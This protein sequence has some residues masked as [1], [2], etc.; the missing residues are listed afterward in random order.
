MP[1]FEG[2]EMVSPH[3]KNRKKPNTQDGRQLRRYKR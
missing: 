1:N 3:R 2:V